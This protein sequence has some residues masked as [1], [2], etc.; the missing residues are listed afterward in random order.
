MIKGSSV[1]LILINYCMIF[2][3]NMIREF[4]ASVDKAKILNKR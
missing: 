2:F 1:N 4:L 3:L